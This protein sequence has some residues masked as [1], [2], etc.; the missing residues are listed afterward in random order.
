M[1]PMHML[2][3]HPRLDPSVYMLI[4]KIQIVVEY[5]VYI[6]KYGDLGISYCT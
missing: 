2:I 5:H 3:I 6:E 1:Q 4:F